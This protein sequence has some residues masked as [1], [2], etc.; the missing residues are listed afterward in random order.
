MLV[1]TRKETES[2]TIIVG[3]TTFNISIRSIRGNNVQI[4]FDAP[5]EITVLRT[6]LLSPK[7]P[8]EDQ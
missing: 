7:P 6:E 5:R 3:E 4:A 1:L 2:V 8:K